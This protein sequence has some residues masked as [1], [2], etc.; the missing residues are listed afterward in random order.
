MKN[1]STTQRCINNA[2]RRER[3]REREK[4]RKGGGQKSPSKTANDTEG[5]SCYLMHVHL[6]NS[7]Q[8][9]DTGAKVVFLKL[10]PNPTGKMV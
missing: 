6:H 7:T 3:E 1:K 2:T 5:C 8:V 9:S 4:G 10:S